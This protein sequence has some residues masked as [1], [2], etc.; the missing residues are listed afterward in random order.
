MER[1]SD[2]LKEHIKDT[3]KEHKMAMEFVESAEKM[4][5]GICNC[6]KDF[7]SEIQSEVVTAMTEIDEGNYEYAKDSL[8]SANENINLL[9]KG[10]D[11]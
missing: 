6:V 5:L 4:T 10:L 1:M 9:W 3:F 8:K 2:E 7:I 11:I